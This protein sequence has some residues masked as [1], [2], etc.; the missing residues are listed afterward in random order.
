M[1]VVMMIE[2]KLNNKVER[3]EAGDRRNEQVEPGTES[4]GDAARYDCRISPCAQRRLKPWSCTQLRGKQR[5]DSRERKHERNK[6][7]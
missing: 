3:Q 6:N 2:K 4:R 7:A 5:E 1:G